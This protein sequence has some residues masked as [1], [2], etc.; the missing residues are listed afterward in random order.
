MAEHMCLKN[1]FT[2][3]EKCHNLMRWLKNKKK[4]KKKKKKIPVFP[5]NRPTL[6]FRADPAIRIAILKKNKKIYSP[7]D[8]F[9]VRKF[10]TKFN[11]NVR[12]AKILNQL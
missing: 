9:F 1:E 10:L 12:I 7:T 8:P 5:L 6:L 4:K 11:E 3:D 2:E